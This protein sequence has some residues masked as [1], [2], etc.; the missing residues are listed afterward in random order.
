MSSPLNRFRV[1][2]MCRDYEFL[3]PPLWALFAA[4]L[5]SFAFGDWPLPHWP[6][7]DYPR[8]PFR[9]GFWR[10]LRWNDA[11]RPSVDWERELFGDWIDED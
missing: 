1:W 6:A 8:S 9:L 10:S 3:P 2:L 4:P 5:L 7:K 11:Q